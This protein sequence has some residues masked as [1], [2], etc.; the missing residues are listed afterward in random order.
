[1]SAS[2]TPTEWPRAAR[3]TARF[4]VT[5]DLPTPPLPDEI[6]SGRVRDPGWANGIGRPSAWPCGCPWAWA[7]PCPLPCSFVRSVLALLVG[8]HGEVERD[9]GDAVDGE[10]RA[11][12]HGLDLVAQRAAGD[13]ER[14]RG[15][16][17]CRRWP[18]RRCGPCRGR[19]SSGA[20]RGPRPDAGRRSAGQR[21]Q[22]SGSFGGA[23]TV[24]SCDRANL[25][26][27]HR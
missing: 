19:R 17:P 15:P 25:H 16:T 4:V 7:W 23:A 10:Q 2:T 27:G 11:V 3:A 14:D 26:Y 5:L 18:A 9:P 13:G 1:M 24:R 12:R 20:A 6:S 21:W 22:A 8:H